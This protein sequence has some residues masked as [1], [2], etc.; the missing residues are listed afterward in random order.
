MIE[1]ARTQKGHGEHI[2]DVRIMIDLI[3]SATIRTDLFRCDLVRADIFTFQFDSVVV[4][5]RCGHVD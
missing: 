2:T 3:K 1:M 4:R 5:L